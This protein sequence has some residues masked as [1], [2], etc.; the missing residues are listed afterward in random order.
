MG[1]KPEAE[2]E[3]RRAELTD[4]I[5]TIVLEDGLDSLALRGLAQKLS[6]SGRML[7]YY[8]KT[9]EALVIAVMQRISERFDDI[10]SRRVPQGKLTPGA[11][12][13][14]A[15]E[16]SSDPAVAPFVGVW[17][18]I[19]ARGA[20]GEQPFQQIA[21]AI[22]AAWLDWIAAQLVPTDPDGDRARAAAIL[23]IVEGT[24]LVE[25]A[26][27]GSTTTARVFLSSLLDLQAE[28]L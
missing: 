12:L 9:K 13:T 14:S 17:T 1:Q 28:A 5:A 22:V 21:Q 20:R 7:L 15:L 24:L 23:S 16:M 6:T 26:R 11:F 2:F 25:A 8:F 3:A 10:L 19:V 27:P 4:Q 18:E